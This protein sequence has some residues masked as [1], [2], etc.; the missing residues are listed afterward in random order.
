VITLTLFAVQINFSYGSQT[1]YFVAGDKEEALKRA[2]LLKFNPFHPLGFEVKPLD[3]VD[4]HWIT[5]KSEFD[6]N[7]NRLILTELFDSPNHEYYY[8][9][10]ISYDSLHE[11]IQ[12]KLPTILTYDQFEEGLSNNPRIFW[13]RN[14]GMIYPDPG[15]C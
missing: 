6:I 2:K 5:C 3:F 10:G 13:N 8:N 15:G 12:N 9:N 4:G 11:I 7:V 1:I 14:R